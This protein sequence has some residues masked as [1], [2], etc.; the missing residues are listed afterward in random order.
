MLDLLASVTTFTDH[1]VS[2][3]PCGVQMR[4]LIRRHVTHVSPEKL[5]VEVIHW[6]RGAGSRKEVVSVEE[7]DRMAKIC[8]LKG[9]TE[10]T[11]L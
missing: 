7:A 9:L 3:S 4:P 6:R 2:P 5:K 10:E 1:S 11:W 8:R